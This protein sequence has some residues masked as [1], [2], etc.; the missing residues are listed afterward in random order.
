MQAVYSS[1]CGKIP[2]AVEWIL[3]SG[4]SSNKPQLPRLNGLSLG[5]TAQ[6]TYLPTSISL[7]TSTNTPQLGTPG[8]VG[9]HRCHDPCPLFLDQQPCAGPEPALRSRDGGCHLMAPAAPS[10]PHH[11]RHHS[12]RRPRRPPGCAPRGQGDGTRSPGVQTAADSGAVRRSP[13][14]GGGTAPWGD[15]GMRQTA[16]SR[17]AHTDVSG[18]G[19]AGTEAETECDP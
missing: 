6:K 13:P 12:R 2:L 5:N 10:P 17:P 8:G 18:T 15:V 1:I 19:W 11:Q 9:H 3:L 14:V 16:S 7:Q 4:L